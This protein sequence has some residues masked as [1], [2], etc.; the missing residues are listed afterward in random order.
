MA[1]ANVSGDEDEDKDAKK[2]DF[3]DVP[4]DEAEGS[5]DDVASD[6]GSLGEMSFAEE[7]TK[8]RF[9]SY[10]MSSSVVTR[11]AGLTLLDDRF[12]K[13]GKSHQTTM[14]RCDYIDSNEMGYLM[15]KANV[16]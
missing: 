16:I 12:E 2:P 1:V 13:T 3:E 6:I 4:S 15:F 5:Y 9:T 8:S 7:E 14:R 10:S 11:N